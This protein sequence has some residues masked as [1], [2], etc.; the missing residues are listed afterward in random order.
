M[1]QAEL[2]QD[3]L[4]VLVQGSWSRDKLYFVSYFSSLF[5]GGMKR[6]WPVR[7][8]VDLFSGPGVCR[9]RDTGEEFLGLQFRRSNPRRHSLTIS[10]TT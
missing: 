3:G 1:Q 2:G 7:A 8:Y 9:D 5:N 10:S 4:P 6:K